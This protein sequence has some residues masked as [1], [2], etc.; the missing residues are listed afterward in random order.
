MV[1]ACRPPAREPARSWLARRSTMA[2]STPASANSP[3]SISPVGPPPAITTACSAI[4][5]PRPR[6]Y[7]FSSRS[8]S[9]TSRRA[10]GRVPDHHRTCRDVL[11][12]DRAG[13]D[14]CLLAD[15]DRRTEDRAAADACAAADGRARASPKA[16]LRATHEV[17]VRRDDTRRNEDVLFERRVGGDVGVGLDLRLAPIV[18]SF[19]TYEPR[20]RTTSSPIATR[21][22]TQDW[23][24]RITRD[25]ISS[26]RRRWRRSRRSCRRR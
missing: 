4:H 23:S 17:V 26:P 5:H 13:A 10:V 8:S 22:R 25:P 16:L 19:S 21:S 9:G 11:R 7:W 14:E 20:P 2:T 1:R 3:A 24:P 6:S 15:L 18:V 12:H